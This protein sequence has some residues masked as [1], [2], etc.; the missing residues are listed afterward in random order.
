MNF[1]NIKK[2]K[3]Q[4]S[5]SVI[6]NFNAETSICTLD[7]ALI[8]DVKLENIIADLMAL[9]FLDIIDRLGGDLANELNTKNLMK[10]L[11]NINQ[12]AKKTIPL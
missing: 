1:F 6:G 12:R 9:D 7:A 3:L 2:N 11:K 4:L 8:L 10:I 5:A